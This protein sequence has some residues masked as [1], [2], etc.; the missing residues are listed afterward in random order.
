VPVPWRSRRLTL[1]LAGTQDLM[2]KVTLALEAV[3][4]LVARGIDVRLIVTGRLRWMADEAEA[5]RVAE[6]HARGCGVADRVS[7]VGPYAQVDAPSIYQR[8]DI[9]L[10]PK[11]NDPCPGVVLEAMACGLPIVYSKSG[12]V[13]ELVG[14]DAGVG[15]P[16]PE[17][18][19]LEY[20]PPAARLADAV[21]EAHERHAGM[22]AAARQRAVD[23][24][25]LRPWID[26]HRSVFES[27][28]AQ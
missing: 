2:Y 3:A 5:A 8:A 28:L 27:L 23:R 13:P 16:A 15:I 10:H 26:R 6:R 19:D 12:G 22:S 25:D 1:L 18:W 20:P 14:D 21:L 17:S 9:L 11:Y 4:L 7:F 24:F